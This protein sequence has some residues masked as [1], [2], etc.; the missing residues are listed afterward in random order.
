MVM[1]VKGT[2][3]AKQQ[4]VLDELSKLRTKNIRS[5]DTKINFISDDGK[6][7]DQIRLPTETNLSYILSRSDCTLFSTL[8]DADCLDEGYV[9][10]L[11]LNDEHLKEFDTR[12]LNFAGILDSSQ[13]PMC[14]VVPT[15]TAITRFLEVHNITA[16]DVLVN[17][18]LREVILGHCLP[19]SSL[20]TSGLLK[21]M[22]PNYRL[23]VELENRQ[24]HRNG[25]EGI[26]PHI[27]NATLLSDVAT[28]QGGVYVVDEMM[29]IAL[30]LVMTQS[31]SFDYVLTPELVEYIDEHHNFSGGKNNGTWSGEEID[32][33]RHVWGDHLTQKWMDFWNN[34]D[35]DHPNPKTE[36]TKTLLDIEPL[37]GPNYELV[38]K[39]KTD[40][41]NVPGSDV[42]KSSD[43]AGVADYRTVKYNFTDSDHSK[44]TFIWVWN[45]SMSGRARGERFVSVKHPGVKVK[46]GYIGHQAVQDYPVKILTGERKS[47]YGGWTGDSFTGAPINLDYVKDDEGNL[48]N[49]IDEGNIDWD[50][51]NNWEGGDGPVRTSK[52]IDTDEV[53]TADFKKSYS[54]KLVIMDT[55]YEWFY[56]ID[57]A[58]FVSV[59]TYELEY[60]GKIEGLWNT[61]IGCNIT[62]HDASD[63][64]ILRLPDLQA[65]PFACYEENVRNLKVYYDFDETGNI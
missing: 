40:P 44:G 38:Y 54:F 8:L 20:D 53:I 58:S 7:F 14:V 63:Q 29:D 24:Y 12:G 2:I 52:I 45:K 9:K 48:T 36:K 56:S 22:L 55:T 65:E 17:P 41:T 49:E 28:K 1:Y 18:K 61:C 30:E 11:C 15:D 23:A 4:D 64:P 19:L 13:I 43:A 60:Q 51:A 21:T 62:S 26:S 3:V 42:W 33:T 16:A 10:D 37:W 31:V 59:G 57:G 25:I 32:H 5:V 47:T 46:L 34:P 27:H 6:L 35:P 50:T 39:G